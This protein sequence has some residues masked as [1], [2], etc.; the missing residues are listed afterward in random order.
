MKQSLLG[1]DSLSWAPSTQPWQWRTRGR[2]NTMA[3]FFSKPFPCK[4]SWRE[5]QT[6]GHPL[7]PNRRGLH[8]RAPGGP[9]HPSP[10]PSGL[11][12][13]ETWKLFLG[14]QY[15][16]LAC[17]CPWERSH[18]E[19]PSANLLLTSY[20]LAR[21]SRKRTPKRLMGWGEG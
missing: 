7:R 12:S 2:I 18:L 11:I 13:F 21:I 3:L 4:S 15:P 5:A 10:P 16:L 17:K 9:S 19:T 8:S 20:F 6:S 14:S 1:P